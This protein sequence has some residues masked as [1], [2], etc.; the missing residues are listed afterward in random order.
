[1]V[2]IKLFGLLR[3][4]SGVK[5]FDAEV[6]S[7]KEIYPLL[8]EKAQQ[9]GKNI[10]VKDIKSSAVLVNNQQANKNTKL[11][12]GDMVIFMSMVAGG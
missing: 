8:I 11:C 3:L 4:D 12:D 10:T 7:V 6:K 9:N 5:E 1:M 2:K